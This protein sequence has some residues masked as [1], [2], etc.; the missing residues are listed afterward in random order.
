MDSHIHQ[1][2]VVHTSALWVNLINPELTQTFLDGK[3]L[4]LF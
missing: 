3:D 1:S 2:K 4:P